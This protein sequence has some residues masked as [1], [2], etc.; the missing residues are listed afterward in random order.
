AR[1]VH[2]QMTGSAISPV[3]PS[4]SMQT[5]ELGIINAGFIFFLSAILLTL[6]FGR[7][8]CGW[9]CHIVALQDACGWIMKKFGIRPSPFRSRLLVFVPLGLALYMFVWPTFKRFALV[10]ALDRV[11]PAAADFIGRPAPFPVDGFRS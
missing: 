9:A 11:A 7:F 6:V 3:E 10:P 5:L 1:I 4:E 8:V 2:W